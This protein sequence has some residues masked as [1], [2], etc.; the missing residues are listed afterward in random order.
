MQKILL[1]QCAALGYEF[2]KKQAGDCRIGSLSFRPADSVFPALTCTVQAT[3]RTAAGPGSHGVGGNG[4]FSR[5]LA[6]AR[7]WE[8]SSALIDGERIWRGFRE[9]G[10]TVG[11][12]FWQQSLGGDS[13]FLLSPAPVHRHGGGIIEGCYSRPGGLYAAISNRIGAGF[14]LRSYWGPMAG[15]KSSLWIR[16]AVK[17]VMEECAPDLLLAYLPHLDY[18]LQA[19]G[20]DSAQAAK[21]FR[22]L[23]AILEEILRFAAD[24]GYGVVVFGD[25][26]IKG[27]SRH[28]L[29]NKALREAGLFRTREVK[30]MLYPDFYASRAFAMVDHQVAQV[31]VPDQKDT[32]MVAEVLGALPGVGRVIG[33][34]EKKELSL[35]H[36]RLGEL[37]VEAEPD[38]WFAYYWWD[39]RRRAPDYA[40]HVDIHNKPGFDPCELFFG[41][42]PFS[43]SM[44]PSRIKGSHGITGPGREVAW[45]GNVDFKNEPDS[46]QGLAG[47]L[48]RLLAEC[49]GV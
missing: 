37:I 18:R 2:L 47:E 30:G 39:E 32:G 14:K 40:T 49:S 8:Q 19:S 28:V 43:V 5:E 11:Q 12:L 21:A 1:L 46:L 9:S 33:E 48:K 7:F 15:V 35:D 13:D 41:R 3:M 20:P 38:S 10:R 17:F 23:S 24:T 22:E 16:D 6:G 26:A 45:A 42:F 27:V 31:I 36:P 29:P 44:R 34:C 25:Y 4:F